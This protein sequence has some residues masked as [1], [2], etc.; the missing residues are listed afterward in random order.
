MP[1]TSDEGIE[2]V[3]AGGKFEHRSS[4]D[5]PVEHFGSRAMFGQY[6]L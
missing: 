2:G 4:F 3:A 5:N 1:V 6:S